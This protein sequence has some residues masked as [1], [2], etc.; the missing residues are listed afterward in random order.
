MGISEIYI[1]LIIGTLL[2]LM[3]VEVTG[4]LPSGLI[5]PGYLALATARE[6]IML[7]FIFL[8]SLVTFIIVNYGV[9]KITILYGKRKFA[10]MITIAILL[11]IVIDFFYNNMY[12]GVVELSAIGTVVPGLIANTIHKQGVIPTVLSTLLLTGFTYGAILFCKTI[13]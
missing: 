4:I 7:V 6:P 3:F 2:T 10:A 9:G 8:I 13:F 12:T 5:V 1:A 11:K